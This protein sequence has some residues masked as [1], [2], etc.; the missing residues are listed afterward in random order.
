MKR[1]LSLCLALLLALLFVPQFTNLLPVPGGEVTVAFAAVDLILESAAPTIE[2]PALSTTN[3]MEG[4]T[5][6][7]IALTAESEIGPGVHPNISQGF[8]ILKEPLVCGT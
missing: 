2:V 7:V 1:F 8:D 6:R 5:S 4:F 3:G